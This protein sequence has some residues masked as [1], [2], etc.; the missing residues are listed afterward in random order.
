MK[1]KINISIINRQINTGT[2][3]LG[4]KTIIIKQNGQNNEN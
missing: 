1:H 2:Y 3:I 4:T